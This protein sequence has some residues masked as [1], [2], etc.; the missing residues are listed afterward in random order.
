MSWVR[1]RDLRQR[2]IKQDAASI[3][4]AGEYIAA[5]ALVALG[6]QTMWSPVAGCDLLC[7]DDE[8]YRVEV[9]TAGARDGA[10]PT[11]FRWATSRGSRVK[12][13][14]STEYCD[15]I[16]LVALPVRRVVFRNTKSI[17][18][19]NTSLSAKHFVE[20]CEAAT[21]AEAKKWKP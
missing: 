7:Y 14:V 1:H 8:F 17:T 2:L 5:A 16:A 21:W 20:G 3:G 10:R 18:G 19:K 4:Q 12:T 6:V 9:K 13:R 15:V 11:M